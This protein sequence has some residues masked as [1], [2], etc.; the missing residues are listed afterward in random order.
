MRRPL[1]IM[2]RRFPNTSLVDQHSVDLDANERELRSKVDR[3]NVLEYT[4]IGTDLEAISHALRR[5]PVGVSVVYQ[6]AA[7]SISGDNAQWTKEKIYMRSS[8]AGITVKLQL[9]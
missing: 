6:S 4:F 1:T 2:E 9:L 5:K 3:R 8:V 7:A